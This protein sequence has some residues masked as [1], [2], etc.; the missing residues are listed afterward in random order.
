MKRKF[1]IVM[2]VSFL[3]ALSSWMGV[4]PAAPG[5]PDAAFVRIERLSQPHEVD[6]KMLWTSPDGS[7]WAHAA[8]RGSRVVMV[9]DGRDVGPYSGIAETPF[10]IPGEEKLESYQKRPGGAFTPDGEVFVFTAQKGDQVHVVTVGADGVREGPPLGRKER[11]LEIIMPPAGHRFA[12]LHQIQTLD[13]RGRPRQGVRLVVDGR[14]S[15]DFA[16]IDQK[17]IIFT[18]DGRHISY[19]AIKDIPDP[20][21]KSSSHKRVYYTMI[22][23]TPGPQFSFIFNSNGLP[24]RA[25]HLVVSDDGPMALY[26]TG[27]PN[28]RTGEIVLQSPTGAI[29]RVAAD[30]APNSIVLTRDARHWAGVQVT[31]NKPTGPKEAATFHHVVYLDGRPGATYDGAY[32]ENLRISPDGTRTAFSGVTTR[33]L[34]HPVIDGQAGLDYRSAGN[35]TFSPD[36]KRL[37]YVAGNDGKQFLVLDGKEHGPYGDVRHVVFSPDGRQAAWAGQVNQYNARAF[38]EGQPGVDVPNPGITWMGFSPS[39]GQLIYMGGSSDVSGRD[40]TRRIYFGLAGEPSFPAASDP[41]ITTDGKHLAFL[42][43]NPGYGDRGQADGGEQPFFVFDGRK[44]PMLKTAV[45]SMSVFSPSGRFVASSGQN[46]FAPLG[47]AKGFSI[48]GAIVMPLNHTPAP[49]WI[50]DNRASVLGITDQGQLVRVSADMEQVAK[51][52]PATANVGAVAATQPTTTDVPYQAQE[53]WPIQNVE[54]VAFKEPMPEAIDTPATSAQPKPNAQPEKQQSAQDGPH[55][56]QQP[57]QV[58][59]K[60]EKPQPKQPVDKAMDN[61]EDVKKKLD[62]VRRLFPR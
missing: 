44:V 33:N 51:T 30:I 43:R 13:P 10:R 45:E 37:A 34:F 8:R 48:N 56:P 2:C 22:D 54:Y 57:Q 59:Q 24:G 42:G 46:N 41:Q 47:R 40:D 25:N 38:L 52:T 29:K 60:P 62:R 58:E 27:K 3:L 12:V 50:A 23:H 49:P 4:L 7:R 17:S 14:N 16:V 20:A 53:S 55:Q 19:V 35:Y 1:K 5:Q 39:D 15:P 18:P 61:A 28:G 32:V 6:A 21:S 11:I 31:T 36:S 26:L 9:V